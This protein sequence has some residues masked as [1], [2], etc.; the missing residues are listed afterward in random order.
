[1]RV[2]YN[3]SRPARLNALAYTQGAEIHV[4]PGQEKTLSHEAWHVV[5]QKQ[6]RVRPTMQL[7]EI[8][9]ND[10]AILENEAD[11]MGAKAAQQTTG[12]DQGATSFI[13]PTVKAATPFPVSLKPVQM[14][15]GKK[16]RKEKKQQ[17]KQA[18]AEKHEAQRESD[19]HEF[20]LAR[21]GS[22]QAVK[23]KEQ[24]RISEALEEFEV[25]GRS[26]HIL[27]RHRH[28]AGVSGKTEFPQGWDDDKILTA[29][30]VVCMN[31]PSIKMDAKYGPS[32]TG[33]YDGVIIEVYFSPIEKNDDPLI[34]STAYPLPDPPRIVPNP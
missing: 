27:N 20:A 31:A 28:G 9:V 22:P 24:E 30:T 16:K 19:K 7:K 17:Q 33:V 14:D 21:A 12:T 5:Q 11:A 3:S 13:P 6:G 2:H 26:A 1:M 15:K 8:S 4:A 18:A 29:I 34:V 23:Q 32:L 25:A 10:D